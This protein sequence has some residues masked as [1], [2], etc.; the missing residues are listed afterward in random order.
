M[1]YGTMGFNLS[2]GGRV[3]DANGLF[4]SGSFF[5][6]LGVPAVIGR[7]MAP[8]DDQHGCGSPSAVIS[9]AFWQREYGSRPSAV[10]S[11]LRLNGRPV[12]VIGVTP[13]SFFGTE[14]GRSYDVAVPLCAEP[15]LRGEDTVFARR[16]GWWLAAIGRLKPGF[17]VTQATAQLESISP[18]VFQATLPRSY[19]A[20]MAKVYLNAKLGAASASSGLSRLRQ[21]Y[22]DPLWLLLALAGA[23]LLIACANL[24]NL[25]FARATVREREF[26]V[27]LALGASRARL[28]EQLLTESLLLAVSGAAAGVLLAQALTRALISFLSTQS[29]Q[30]FLDQH[31]D[32]RVLGFTAGLA[33]LTCVLFGLLPAIRATKASPATA[34]KASSRGATSTRERF[35]LRRLLVVTQ[36]ALSL[37]LL[38]GALL[39]VRTFQNLLTLDPGFQPDGILVAHVDLRGVNLPLENRISFKKD[40]LAH[41]RAVPGVESAAETSVIPVTGDYW[42][43]MVHTNA[44]GQEVRASVNFDSISPGYFRTMET[45]ILRGRDVDESDTLNSPLVAM[46]NESFVRKMLAGK[47]AIGKTFH[48]ETAP[49]KPE[50]VYQIIGV[51]QDTKYVDLREQSSAIAYVSMS[52]AKDPDIG[53]A[54]FIRSNIAPD[55][56]ASSLD[57]A[58]RQSNPVIAFQFSVYKTAIRDTLVRERLMATLSGFFGFLAVLLATIGLY[59]VMSY[60][61]ARRTN[62]IGIRMALGAD[63]GNVLA[64]VL[65]EAGVL[66]A[67]GLAVGTVLSLIVGQSAQA[68]LFGLQPRDPVT[69]AAAIAFMAMVALTASYLPAQRAARLDPMVALREE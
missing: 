31:L 62:E 42:N 54:F 2:A 29:S 22:E 24:A 6:V 33:V 53:P 19:N 27:R 15:L 25:M 16:D 50:L 28:L 65:R 7:I 59:G 9:Y 21:K 39:F 63:R 13:A 46:V 67:A 26:A 51:V 41:L 34:M 35:G 69:L 58:I 30:V 17:T 5:N 3:R 12:E 18:G 37:V 48:V 55:A 64:M 10:G 43:D 56:L 40:L 61:V 68:M 47:D 49:G 4:V 14:V 60:M 36:V 20:E 32:W 11:M 66:L 44:S 38:V 45:S 52:Q 23:V 8:A 1:A 57:R